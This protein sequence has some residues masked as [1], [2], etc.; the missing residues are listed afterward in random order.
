M[1]ARWPRGVL[2]CAAAAAAVPSWGM[3][4]AQQHGVFPSAT[5]NKHFALQ[6]SMTVQLKL[7]SLSRKEVTLLWLF[8][9]SRLRLHMTS[10]VPGK[11]YRIKGATDA[12]F[13]ANGVFLRFVQQETTRFWAKRALC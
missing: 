6:W 3:S 11:V 12:W 1:H 2:A 8:D 9:Q 4:A 7:H 13:I 5:A 10:R